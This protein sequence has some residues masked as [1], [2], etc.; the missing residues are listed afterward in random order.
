MVADNLIVFHICFLCGIVGENVFGHR[1][2]SHFQTLLQV[3]VDS[4]NAVTLH[5][6]DY[7]ERKHIPLSHLAHKNCEGN[8][9]SSHPL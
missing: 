2:T 1:A 6:M 5:V 8:L 7:K 3:V 4:I 9:C